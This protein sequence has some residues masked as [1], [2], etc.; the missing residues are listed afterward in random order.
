[1]DRVA[2]A[3][4]SYLLAERL[5]GWS[6]PIQYAWIF[7]A[8]P[9]EKALAAFGD[10]LG[11]GLLSR[12]VVDAVVPFARDRW[13]RSPHPPFLRIDPTPIADSEVG[14]WTDRVLRTADLDPAAGK[15]WQL[16]GV[17]TTSGKFALSLLISHMV[18]DGHGL[19]NALAAAHTGTSSSSLRRAEDLGWRTRVLGDLRDSVGQLAEAATASRVVATEL[20]RQRRA[21]KSKPTASA[22]PEPPSAVVSH[23]GAAASTDVDVTSSRHIAAQADRGA[24]VPAAEGVTVSSDVGGS[25]LPGT[26][27]TVSSHTNTT[28]PPHADYAPPSDPSVDRQSD[29]TAGARSH[30]DSGAASSAADPDTT[31]AIVDVDRGQWVARAQEFGGTGN[32]LFTAVL[33]GI[34]HR[35]GYSVG[36]EGLRVCMAVS[37]RAEGDE[38]ANASGGVWIRVPGEISPEKGLGGIRALSKQALRDYESAGKDKLADNLQPVVRLL[39]KPLIRKLMLSVAGPDTTVSNLGAAPESALHVG[40]LRAESFAIRAIMQG[41]SGVERRRQGPAIAAWAVEYDNKITITFFGIDPD[42]FGESER[43]RKTIDAEL[44]RWG[45][46]ATPW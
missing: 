34:V 8:V 28:V 33:G 21:G 16:V 12:K 36:A 38:R 32:S 7:G 37:K 10:Q 35:C 19:Y 2:G 22:N 29:R 45:L 17:A 25:S 18:A 13:V 26:D 27:V 15:G 24:A 44:D 14:A 11:S 9:E 42:H 20:W 1:M 41:R 43:L 3:D 5:F 23:T 31:L 39:P 30:A 4:E 6:A 40:G 46:S